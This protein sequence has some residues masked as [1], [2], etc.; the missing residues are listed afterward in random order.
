MSFPFGNGVPRRSIR[1]AEKQY[2]ADFYAAMRRV[3]ADIHALKTAATPL[4]KVKTT[5]HLLEGL[6]DENRII[7]AHPLTR[8]MYREMFRVLPQREYVRDQQTVER[9]CIYLKDIMENEIERHEG[10]QAQWNAWKAAG[11]V[12]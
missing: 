5:I 10:M 11:L 12:H 1:I 2:A 9:L 7:L 6:M 3:R 4:A 8:S